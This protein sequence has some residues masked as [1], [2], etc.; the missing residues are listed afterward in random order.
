MKSE[1]RHELLENDLT[2]YAEKSIGWLKSY[3][4]LIMV[5]VCIVSIAASI[6]IYWQRVESSRKQHAWGEIAVA[7]NVVDFQSIISDPVLSKT[8][9]AP[10]AMIQA[11]EHQL[12]DGIKLMFT[13]RERG[14]RELEASRESFD[15]ILQVNPPVEAQIRER[16]LYGLA[17]S[18]E[19]LSDGKLAPAI[20]SYEK[21]LSEFPDSLFK[22]S[23]EA[24]IKE[25]N[26]KDAGEFYAWFAKQKPTTSTTK[27]PA[28]QKGTG[29]VLKGTP[30]KSTSTKDSPTQELQD[31]TPILKGPEDDK[32][33]LPT[34]TDG[35][36]LPKKAADPKAPS[37]TTPS[38]KGTTLPEKNAADK[39][40]PKTDLPT[41]PATP[42]G[43]ASKS[44][45]PAL[46][47]NPVKT[48]PS[49]VDSVPGKAEKS[50]TAPKK[51]P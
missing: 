23:A 18:Q 2:K 26:R 9:V 4:N 21:L 36:S 11:A 50:V 27:L 19:S 45:L 20:K 17:K 22:K 46:P 40:L 24:R 13:E 42:K 1:Q 48:E 7:R 14:K 10:W 44:E 15:A 37:T 51:N 29:R 30:G 31:S 43:A 5:L 34:S 28:D 32:D 12:Q 8:A 35:D 38:V 39:A 47:A 16:A 41:V 33:G 49:K 6:L 3:G 25:L